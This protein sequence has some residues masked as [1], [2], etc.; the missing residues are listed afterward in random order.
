MGT[1]EHHE[2]VVTRDVGSVHRSSQNNQ[3][4]IK[5]RDVVTLFPNNLY[6][7]TRQKAVESL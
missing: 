3:E 6:K 1:C 4:T 7:L 2:A 5:K